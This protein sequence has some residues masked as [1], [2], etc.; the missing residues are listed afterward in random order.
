MLPLKQENNMTIFPI[1]SFFFAPQQKTSKI[2]EQLQIY[3]LSDNYFPS[4]YG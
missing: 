3:K 4:I 1:T 2:N